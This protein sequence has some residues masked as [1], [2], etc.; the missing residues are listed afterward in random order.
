[1]HEHYG[2]L[3]GSSTHGA[4]RGPF[5]GYMLPPSSSNIRES[6]ID[7]ENRYGAIFLNQTSSQKRCKSPEIQAPHQKEIYLNETISIIMNDKDKS[8]FF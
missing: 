6:E 3:P 8:S 5:G 7:D 2:S 4:A 1:M